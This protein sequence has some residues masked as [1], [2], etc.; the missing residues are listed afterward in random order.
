MTH[1]SLFSGI[2]GFDLSRRMVRFY[3]PLSIASGKNFLAKSSNTISPMQNNMKTSTI[4]TQL[5]I[6]DE[7]TSSAEDSP[8][9]RSVLQANEKDQ[10]MNATSGQ[11]CLE[12]SESVNRVGSWA[13]T[14][15]GLLVGRTDWFSKR[16]AL[17]WKL[18]GTP[19]NRLLFQ[20]VPQAMRPTDA[21]EFGLLPTVNAFD[22]NTPR[23]PEAWK[24]AKEKHG[25]TL[26]NPLKQMASVGM[27][28]TPTTS[29]QNAGTEV[30]RTD[31]VS[32]RSELNHLMS[33]E[34]GKSSQLSPLF[35]GEMMGFPKNWTVSPFQSGEENQ[36]KHTETP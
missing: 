29:C 17:T 26:Q 3:K 10:K 33:Q 20:L 6:M 32:R 9:N 24:N 35:V 8:V 28:P 31:G 16:V 18:L 22:W 19:S 14:F 15:A 11:R 34:A 30:E 2:G 21:T 1:G 4:S 13:R 23:S 12:L 5:S 27:L 25:S 7:L 36:S